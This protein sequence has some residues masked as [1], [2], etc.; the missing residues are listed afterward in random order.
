[1][2]CHYVPEQEAFRARLRQW[3]E[4]NQV[5][6]FGHNRDMLSDSDAERLSKEKPVR[7][8]MHT[9]IQGFALHSNLSNYAA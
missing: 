1:M 2:D 7:K 4:R 3:L 8:R 9:R 5:E 6:V